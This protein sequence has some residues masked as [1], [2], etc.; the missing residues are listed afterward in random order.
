ML[1]QRS[2]DSEALLRFALL[3]A[4]DATASTQVLVTIADLWFLLKNTAYHC[5]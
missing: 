1:S 2:F 3:L 4:S 5:S